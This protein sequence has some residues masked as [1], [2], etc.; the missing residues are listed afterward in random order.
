MALAFICCRSASIEIDEIEV[1][2]K[3][4]NVNRLDLTVDT[5]RSLDGEGEVV[6]HPES[7]GAFPATA[8]ASLAPPELDAYQVL[9]P[10]GSGAH[11]Q[12]VLIR[13][14]KNRF[15]YAM[16]ILKKKEVIRG[17]QVE[18]TK[19]E[20]NILET[21]KHPFIVGLHA[22]FQCRSSLYLIIEYC[23]G[24]ELLDTIRKAVLGRL[25]ESSA[26]FY[27]AGVLLAVEKL[28][29]SD[30]L[31]RDL[32]PENV[33]IDADGYAKLTDFGLAKKNIAGLRTSLL[34]VGTEQYWAPEVMMHQGYSRAADW[35]SFGCLIHEMLLGTPPD[36]PTRSDTRAQSLI[37]TWPELSTNAAEV[38][39]GLLQENPTDR[40]GTKGGIAKLKRHRFFD[41]LNFEELLKKQVDAPF[42]PEIPPDDDDLEA[43][44][45][46]KRDSK[47]SVLSASDNTFSGYNYDRPDEDAMM[48]S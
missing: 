1:G 9:K 4:E 11:G 21:V 5:T 38:L 25:P 15:L 29:D 44:L 45:P 7:L 2:R 13:N 48:G 37:H 16:K 22:A 39:V 14:K 12:V 23:P 35:Y 46:C 36:A 8:N 43:D 24:G 31:Y 6:E 26:Q 18:G 3:D 30:I 41:G 33:L 20:R 17:D 28:H 40:L 34:Q 47:T 27:G 42:V 32:K 19:S 10:L